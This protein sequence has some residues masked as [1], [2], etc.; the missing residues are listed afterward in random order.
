MTDQEFIRYIEEDILYLR[1]SRS[2]DK[3]PVEEVL[4]R[5]EKTIQEAAIK[6]LGHKIPEKNIYREVVSGGEAIEDRPEFIKVLKRLEIGN[7]RRVWVID[8]QRLSRSGLYGAGDV[9]EAF[10]VTDTLIATPMKIY[11]LSNPMDKKYLEMIMIQAAE[12]LNYAKEVMN[13]GR[14]TSFLEGKAVSTPPFGYDKEK[15]KD[16]KGY[17]LIPHPIEADYVKTMFDL[18]VEGLGTTNIA[19][20]LNE[21]KIL[22]RNNNFWIPSTVRDV[23]TNITYIGFLTW[24]KHKTIKKLINGKTVKRRVKKKDKEQY[25]IAQGLHEP[26]ITVEQFDHAQEMLKRKSTGTV[27]NQSVKNPLNG[28][29]KCGY[30]GGAMIRRP[31]TK[32]FRKN[33]V[34]VYEIDKP[35]LLKFLREKKANTK[36]SLTDIA[37]KLDLTRD[38]VIGW[39]PTK[40]EKFYPS[41]TLADKWFELK[42]LL[43]FTEDTFDKV[44]TTYEDPKPQRDTLLCITYNCKCVSSFLEDVE[45][46]VIE[47][48]KEEVKTYQYY[49]DNY[50]QEMKKEKKSNAK[51]I[52]KLD[53]Q[54]EDLKE[55]IKNARKLMIKQT[56]SEEEY[57]EEKY[58]FEQEL[59]PLEKRRSELENAEEEEKIIQ[60]KKSIPVLEHCIEKYHTLESAADKND[61]LREIIEQ[62]KYK[63]SE[64]GRWNKEA[65][66]E[67]QLTIY[68]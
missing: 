11:D 67:L 38:V 43:G 65:T 50:E 56:I 41:Q 20:Y 32:S 68:K 1:K 47:K 48:L 28:L 34:R 61:L 33:P 18:C 42:E 10:E 53:K 58:E 9:L 64:N 24:E 59:V 19:N 12:Y 30:C 21:N 16:E 35:A 39:F 31:Y 7:I 54:I 3:L 6:E 27:N 55:A 62:I 49:L 29:V 15:L 37:N 8:P 46:A 22:T 63:K 26:I 51:E 60:Y 40:V 14:L 57:L 52:R 25:Y 4:K 17:K 13:R 44:V 2:E 5:H 36:L 45:K 23:L 66:F